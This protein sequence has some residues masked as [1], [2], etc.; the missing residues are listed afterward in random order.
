MVDCVNSA[1]I[2]PGC[3]ICLYPFLD[4]WAWMRH[5]LYC[6]SEFSPV[7]WRQKELWEWHGMLYLDIIECA[8]CVC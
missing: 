5:L 3:E 7:K 6:A 2:V 4:E 1:G 8:F